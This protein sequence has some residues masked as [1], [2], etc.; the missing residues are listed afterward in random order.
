MTMTMAGGVGGGPGTWNIYIRVLYCLVENTS[1]TK[2]GVRKDQN[3]MYVHVCGFAPSAITVNLRS[4][5]SGCKPPKKRPSWSKQSGW[6]QG[7]KP[8]ESGSRFLFLGL[9]AIDA[10][11]TKLYVYKYIHIYTYT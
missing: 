2:Q 10:I 8:A 3:S 11:Y 9:D 1:A 5:M 6:C 7:L 4:F